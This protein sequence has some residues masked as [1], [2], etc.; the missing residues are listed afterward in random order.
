MYRYGVATCAVGIAAGETVRGFFG[1]AAGG[2]R[3]GTLML[4]RKMAKTYGGAVH[5]ESS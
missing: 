3:G 4:R 1:I 5:V 2:P